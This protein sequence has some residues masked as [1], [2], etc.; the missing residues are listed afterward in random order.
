MWCLALGVLQVQVQPFS[1]YKEYMKGNGEYCKYEHCLG[2]YFIGTLMDFCSSNFSTFSLSFVFLFLA[3]SIEMH[4]AVMLCQ[5]STV[6]I[7]TGEGLES[8]L[9]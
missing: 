9:N 8:Q 2:M 1:I 5:G 4:V 7:V 3:P 6:G